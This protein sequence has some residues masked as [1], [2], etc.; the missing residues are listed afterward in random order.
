LVIREGVWVLSNS[1]TA[2]VFHD[3][4]VVVTVFSAVFNC[5]LD[6]TSKR[7]IALSVSDIVNLKSLALWLEKNS[8]GKG[9]KITNDVEDDI[10]YFFFFSGTSSQKSLSFSA[11]ATFHAADIRGDNLSAD[12]LVEWSISWYSRSV[13]LF[14]SHWLD[15]SLNALSHV[16]DFKLFLFITIWHEAGLNK[17]IASHLDTSFTAARLWLS[18]SHHNIRINDGVDKRSNSSERIKEKVCCFLECKVTSFAR[19]SVKS[20]DA[21][22]INVV[23]FTWFLTLAG[24]SSN[25]LTTL[26]S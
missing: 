14:V 11:F 17:I 15:V 1:F 7:S 5:V 6:Y 13:S 16:V 24:F 9:A 18:K 8:N 20:I 22:T 26:V 19:G 10:G 3:N 4:L 25:V 23:V 2:A 21:H 12:N